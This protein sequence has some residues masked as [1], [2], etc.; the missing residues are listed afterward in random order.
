MR[1]SIA[2]VC[3]SGTLT[4]KLHAIAEAGFDGVEIFEPDLVAS[5]ASPEEIAALARR[6]GLTLDLYQPFRDAEGVS[7]D[8]FSTVIRRARAKFRLMQRM[9]IDTMLVCSNVATATVDDDAVSGDQLRRLGDEAE[10][11]GVRLAYEALGWGRYVNDY[12]R[13]WRIV[14]LAD[15]PAVG[16]CLDSF[17]ILSRGSDPE[18][19][20][21]IPGEKIFFLQLADAPALT[22]DILSWSRHHRL[23]PGEG[24]FDLADFMDHVIRAG[25]SGPISLEVFNDTFRQTE[26]HRT[27][28]QAKRS[29][30]WL[31]DQT[32]RRQAGRAPTPSL[33][34]L[35]DVEQPVVFDFAE[36]KAEDTGDVELL[37][38]QLGF[39]FGGRHRSKP[40]RLWKQGAA[41]VVCNEQQARDRSPAVAAVGF[42]V[43]DPERSTRRARDLKAPPV[44]R[45]T[46]ASEQELSGFRAPDGT[47]VFLNVTAD[48]PT[49][50]AEFVD[51]V[52]TGGAALLTGIDHVNLAHPWQ[53][54]DESVLFYGSVLALESGSSQEVA[55]PTGLVRSHVVRS[56]NGGVRLALN[57]APLAFD[58]P[59][60]FP[61]HVAFA[62]D[63]AVAVARTARERGLRSL[64]IPANYYDDLM[65]RF[66]LPPAYVAELKT[67]GLL[68]DR[69]ERG[70]FLQF[71]TETVGAV[72]F[73][74]VQRIDGYEG[75][76]AAN[77]P[78]RLA[79]QHL[80][81]ARHRVYG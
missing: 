38:Q 51:G 79:A 10:K 69:D 49:W 76:G 46:H 67:L 53:D 14:E 75:Y 39:A 71:Y 62:C 44:Y 22:M 45:R 54:F 63:D 21:R 30:T 42:Q 52:R 33:R 34:R 56:A 31:E 12:R 11:H 57:V 72:F 24:S 1:T 4:E 61:Q 47:E 59:E 18:A 29:L 5:P 65:A 2:T 7:D 23:F 73:E 68:Y 40:V 64:P 8:M 74:V 77:A 70:E 55:A 19:I 3:V 80:H 17:H 37:L 26:V 13:A 78:V 16:T 66:E 25:Y 48:E 6:L 28:M 36:V 50:V 41:R 81:A 27:A 32:A 60:G 15:H 58:H 9:G 43:A 35:P 20:E